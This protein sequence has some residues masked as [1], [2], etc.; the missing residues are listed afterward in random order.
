MTDE[1]SFAHTEAMKEILP[2]FR[3]RRATPAHLENH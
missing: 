3:E 2:A 1:L